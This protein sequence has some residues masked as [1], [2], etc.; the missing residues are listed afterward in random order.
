MRQ[1]LSNTE[2]WERRRDLGKEWRRCQWLGLQRAQQPQGRH[3]S[4][5]SWK[6]ISNFKFDNIDLLLPIKQI[7]PNKNPPSWTKVQIW[8]NKENLPPAHGAVGRNS[9]DFSP[10]TT[11]FCKS[12]LV[13]L[14]RILLKPPSEKLWHLII[15]A[16]FAVWS[17]QPQYSK[18]RIEPKLCC[19]L[20]Y[21]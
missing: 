14:N 7:W 3:R 6:Q 17:K 9:G 18:S 10:V 19:R 5:P 12:S 2:D 11:L 4:P 1:R 15:A 8:P 21:S 16:V 20:N 13:F